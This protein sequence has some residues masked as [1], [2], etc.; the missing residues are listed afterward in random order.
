MSVYGYRLL[1]NYQTASKPLQSGTTRRDS[2]VSDKSLE[3]AYYN[4][5]PLSGFDLETEEPIKARPFKPKYHMT[6]GNSNTCY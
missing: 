5:E 6:M 2:A 4:I 1:S 3:D